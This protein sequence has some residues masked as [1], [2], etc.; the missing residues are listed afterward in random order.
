MQQVNRTPEKG[1]LEST[2]DKG[3]V[4]KVLLSGLPRW[5]QAVGADSVLSAGDTVT[6]VLAFINPTQI[7]CPYDARVLAGTH[8]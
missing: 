8:H 7:S 3:Q 1:A 2:S 5:P 4:W 6:T